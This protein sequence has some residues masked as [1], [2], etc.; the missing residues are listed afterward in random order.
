MDDLA[1]DLDALPNIGNLLRN[2][3]QWNLALR[4]LF[5]PSIAAQWC[6]EGPD[7][8]PD[9]AMFISNLWK[10]ISYLYISIYSVNYSN[11]LQLHSDHRALLLNECEILKTMMIVFVDILLPWYYYVV[12]VIHLPPLDNVVNLHRSWWQSQSDT[13]PT[14]CIPHQW[15]IEFH[16]SFFYFKKWL[17]F[18]ITMNGAETV[19]KFVV[20]F[21]L[22]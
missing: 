21:S 4:L 11:V 14:S 9:A 18:L 6:L 16:D 7:A 10:Y 1:R 19:Y 17:S 3:S 22:F 12:L 2:P 5:G 20:I 13:Y 8:Y 15:G